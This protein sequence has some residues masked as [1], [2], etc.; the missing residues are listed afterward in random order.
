MIKDEIK[1][2]NNKKRFKIDKKPIKKI[3]ATIERTTK[4][5]DNF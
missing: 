5:E 2:K 3:M 4:W 1:K